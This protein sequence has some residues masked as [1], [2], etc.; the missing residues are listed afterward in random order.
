[1]RLDWAILS[2]AA[3]I[4]AGLA[5]VLGGGWDTGWRAEF[6]APF[7]GAMTVRLLVHPTEVNRPHQLELRFWT[8]D[9]ADFAAPLRID[10]GPGQVPAE[11]PAGQELPALLA[12]GLQGLTVPAPGHYSIEIL[13]DDRHLQSIPFQMMQ[14]PPPPPPGVAP[15]A[16][17]G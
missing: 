10:L 8:A 16:A 15:Q 3:E 12:I 5:Y 7:L 2:N 1:L 17:Q 6:P 9:G 4:Q 13:V 14:G 11:R